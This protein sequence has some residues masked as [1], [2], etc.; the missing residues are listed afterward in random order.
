LDRNF[1]SLG[2]CWQAGILVDFQISHLVSLSDYKI[3]TSQN[4]AFSQ[5]KC[6]SEKDFERIVFFMD[7]PDLAQIPKIQSC[8][9]WSYTPY[10]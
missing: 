9:F 10:V 3:K 4:Q 2:D 1:T 6:L 7:I 8:F 5:K